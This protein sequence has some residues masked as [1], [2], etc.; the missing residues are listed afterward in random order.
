MHNN[1]NICN[2]TE[3]YIVKNGNFYI[4]VLPQIKT[5]VVILVFFMR[6][7]TIP[8]CDFAM[9]IISVNM[10]EA[11]RAKLDILEVFGVLSFSVLE[12]G[13]A[14]GASISCSMFVAVCLFL[15]EA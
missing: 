11:L 12:V 1:V 5:K 10:C 9:R 3:L 8:A 13:F 2:T 15:E 4:L 7:I 14:L 6:L